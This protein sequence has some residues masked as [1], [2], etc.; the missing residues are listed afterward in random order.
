MKFNE[1]TILCRFPKN[2][3]AARSL[4]HSDEQNKKMNIYVN[5]KHG[6]RR[7]IINVKVSR[8]IVVYTTF[9]LLFSH[10]RSLASFRTRW[11]KRR[12]AKSKLVGSDT[13]SNN[14]AVTY[15]IS[16]MHVEREKNT[17]AENCVRWSTKQELVEKG[18]KEKKPT[19]FIGKFNWTHIERIYRRW[20]VFFLQPSITHTRPKWK[21]NQRK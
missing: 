2:G 12:N 8:Q 15:V 4:Y 11:R 20:A 3:A 19:T 1:N 7:L 6:A 21:S 9:S 14:G 10:A 13:N 16:K 5:R 18:K 17:V